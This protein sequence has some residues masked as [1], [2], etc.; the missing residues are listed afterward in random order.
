MLGMEEP[1]NHQNLVMEG[2]VDFLDIFGRLD[3]L[4]RYDGVDYL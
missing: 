4:G 2:E 3:N 1:N